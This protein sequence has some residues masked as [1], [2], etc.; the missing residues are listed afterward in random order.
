MDRDFFM[1]AQESLE[2]GLID[3]VIEERP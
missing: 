3:K 1:S 2:Y